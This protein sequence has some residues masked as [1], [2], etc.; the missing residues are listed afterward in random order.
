MADWDL[1]VVGAG[2]AGIGAG[3]VAR[4]A[5]MSFKILEASSRIGGRTHTIDIAGIPFDLGAHYLHNAPYNAFAQRALSLGQELGYRHTRGKQPTSLYYGSRRADEETRA[6]CQEYY[7]DAFVVPDGVDQDIAVADTVDTSSPYYQP[8]RHFFAAVNGLPPEDCSVP[9]Y[10]RYPEAPYDWT[11]K[12]GYGALV[13]SLADGLNIALETPVTAIDTSGSSVRVETDSGSL[14][15]K[16]VVVTVSVSVLASNAIRFTPALP[17]SLAQAFV[18]VPLGFA[19]RSVLVCDRPLPIEL[20]GVV[21]AMPEATT[22]GQGAMLGMIFGEFDRPTVGGY[23]AAELAEEIARAEGAAGLVRH[24]QETA[25]E[26]L[27]SDWR[28]SFTAS[29]SSCWTADPFIGGAYSAARAG[30]ATSRDVLATQFDDRLILAGEACSPHQYGTVHGAYAT[31]TQA[32][33]DLI[34]A[35]VLG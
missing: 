26:I 24:T 10:Q 31:G 34:Q 7:N 28:D 14:T 19:E 20:E 5:G 3:L 18:D 33:A 12:G 23:F 16:A 8:F 1:I 11:V 32:V 25:I 2:A 17:D 30:H 35:E 21:H 27:G 15:A 29:A 13:S 6:A 4:S 22:L 9:D